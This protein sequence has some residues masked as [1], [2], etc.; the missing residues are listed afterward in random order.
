MPPHTQGKGGSGSNCVP[1]VPNEEE[2]LRL[3]RGPL[4]SLKPARKEPLPP[5]PC[6]ALCPR[7]IGGNSHCNNS[8]ASIPGT[9]TGA[10]LG[11]TTTGKVL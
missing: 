9:N 11:R 1:Q 2:V 7:K 8:S 3:L 10:G 4:D 6:S 5:S